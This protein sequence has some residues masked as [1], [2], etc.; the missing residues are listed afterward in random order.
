MSE[1]ARNVLSEQRVPFG[2]HVSKPFRIE[3]YQKFKC[4]I[5]LDE[6]MLRRAKEI[7]DG[8]PDK[9]IRLFTNFHG[10]RLNF[11]D[12]WHTGNYRRAYEE[13]HLGCLSL[14]K[15]IFG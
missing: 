5:A 8:D 14:L 13:I 4:I 15:E 7:A 9:K 12:P 2:K 10:R 1:G 11:D 6:K 3:E